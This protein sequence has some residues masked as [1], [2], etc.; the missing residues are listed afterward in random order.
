MPGC[1]F[2]REKRAVTN[3]VFIFAHELCFGFVGW[4]FQKSKV[5]ILAE[6]AFKFLSFIKCRKSGNAR[7]S[8]GRNFCQR[9]GKRQNG[10]GKRFTNATARLIRRAKKYKA[11]LCFTTKRRLNFHGKTHSHAGE[12]ANTVVT[13]EALN[14][15]ARILKNPDCSTSLN[16]APKTDRK[17]GL[18]RL[19]KGIFRRLSGL[20]RLICQPGKFWQ[21]K[22]ILPTTTRS[23]YCQWCSLRSQISGSDTDLICICVLV[24]GIG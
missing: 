7:A 23:I 15:P 17:L 3:C 6:K 24:L 22:N 8:N 18:Y 2:G 16:P 12:N 10:N 19:K 4:S 14:P 21:L 13:P 11:K 9:Q 5:L 20:N 1:I